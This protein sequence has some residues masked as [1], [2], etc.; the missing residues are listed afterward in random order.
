M[1]DCP[2]WPLSARSG[3]WHFFRCQTFEKCSPLAS[4]RGDSTS[5]DM[6]TAP[7]VYVRSLSL[8]ISFIPGHKLSERACE[9]DWIHRMNLFR[10][11]R[12][13]SGGECRVGLV[14]QE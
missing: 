5:T 1:V 10:Y 8:F 3:P 4:F 9:S 6:M 14:V 11:T 12:L 13:R 2:R 7:F